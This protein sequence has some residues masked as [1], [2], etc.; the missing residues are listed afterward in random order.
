[1][2]LVPNDRHKEWDGT[3]HV[4]FVKHSGEVMRDEA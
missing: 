2:K 1:M 4:S 3:Y